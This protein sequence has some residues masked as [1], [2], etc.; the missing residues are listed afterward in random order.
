[1]SFSANPIVSRRTL[2][3]GVGAGVALP[4]LEAM[5]PTTALASTPRK[6]P[7]RLGFFYVPNGVRMDH[8]RCGKE[9]VASD[10]PPILQPLGDKDVTDQVL[11]LSNLK[12]DHCKGTEAGHEPAG[13]GFLVGKRCKRSEEAEVGGASIDQWVAAR[14]GQATNV[15]ALALGIDPGH[16][17]DHGYSGSYLSHVSWRN[18]TTP[19][20]LELNPRLLYN[21][22]FRGRKLRRPNW[23]ETVEPTP[24][25]RIDPVEASILDL[26][27]DDTQRLQR[28]LGFA[29]RRRLGEYLEGLRNIERRIELAE[30]DSHSHHQDSFDEDPSKIALHEGESLDDLPELIMPRGEGIPSSYSEHVN[31]MLDILT[32][33]FQTDTTRVSSFMFSFEKS[34]RSYAEAG[35]PGSHHST[36]HHQ[37]K[38]KNLS[39]LTKVNTFHMDLFARMLQRMSNIQEGESTLLDNVALLY[40]SGISD[41]NKHNHDDLPILIAG[42]GGGRIDSGRHVAFSKPT[43]LCNVYLDMLACAGVPLK[44]FGDSTGRTRRLAGSS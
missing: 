21:R 6:P 31:L 7:V 25:S 37:S 15:D 10:L 41:G 5:E 36:S 27:R 44:Q 2:L 16:R 3:R 12:A 38:E 32:L 11:M 39:L 1:M 30:K 35:A 24:K 13:G 14:I 28:Q 19:A 33:A 29:D 9:L 17:G 22:L 43:P 23:G 8:W 40:G 34:N 20:T 42:G 18:K 4:W 26:I